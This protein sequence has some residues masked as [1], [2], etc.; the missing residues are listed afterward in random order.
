MHSS[1]IVVPFCVA[2]VAG[3]PLAGDETNIPEFIALKS[4]FDT[5]AQAKIEGPYKKRVSE[6]NARYVADLSRAESVAQTAG[7]LADVLALKAERDSVT[8]GKPIPQKDEPSTPAT[9]KRLRASYRASLT[10]LASDRSR[11]LAPL[12]QKYNRE[13]DAIIAKL[14]KQGKLE[15]AQLVMRAKSISTKD[16]VGTWVYRWGAGESRTRIFNADG[17]LVAPE[18][19]REPVA[20]WTFEPTRLVVRWDNGGVDEFLFPL[21][22]KEMKGKSSRG[23]EFVATKEK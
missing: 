15:E 6:L 21:N 22:P 16:L 13:V 17:S 19:G 3:Y 10:K 1:Q 18:A 9:L 14:T 4:A 23:F 20:R 2:I 12:A 8:E 5:E 7:K 11:F